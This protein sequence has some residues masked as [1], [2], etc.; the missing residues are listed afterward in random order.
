VTAAPD[1]A[2]VALLADQLRRAEAAHLVDQEQ[3]GPAAEW[4]QWYAHHLS[5]T[6]GDVYREEDLLA[7]LL[8]AASAEEVHERPS[9][10]PDET[11]P[12]R[13]AEH[14][15]ARLSREWRLRQS[16]DDAGWDG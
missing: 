13:Y 10:V 3:H 12:E 11:W 14:M 16:A 5:R 1:P 4:P 7:A 6:L 9:G 2:F 8:D 15:A